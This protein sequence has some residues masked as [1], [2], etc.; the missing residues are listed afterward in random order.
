MW[1]RLKENLYGGKKEV[2]LMGN[3]VYNEEGKQKSILVLK[4]EASG[5]GGMKSIEATGAYFHYDT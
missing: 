5:K 4:Q 1:R 2:Y 3:G